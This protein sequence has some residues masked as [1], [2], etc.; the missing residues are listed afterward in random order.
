MM[1]ALPEDIQE[2]ISR[3]IAE[4]H[5][6][7]HEIPGVLIVHSIPGFRV[8]YM[9]ER[10][11]KLLETSLE[12]LQ[13]MGM[14]Y[15][16]RY[17]NE[18]DA[19]DYIPKVAAMVAKNNPDEMVSFFQQVRRFPGDSWS[20][21][22]SATKIFLRH[23][24]GSPLLT[25]TTAVPVDPHQH[26]TPKVSRLLDENSFSRTHQQLFES[27]TD[28]EKEILKLLALSHSAAEIAAMLVISTHTV[29]THRKNLRKKLGITTAYELT[30]FASAFNL[31]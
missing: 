8:E 18:E 28:R 15:Y 21:Y 29:E 5:K 20:W 23:D 11:L 12:D 22:F 9:S 14:E 17:F 10:G 2:K 7:A 1:Q 25:I 3:K 6:T 19:A 27:L 4:L 16:S 26:V 30:R 31:I 13:A 24:D